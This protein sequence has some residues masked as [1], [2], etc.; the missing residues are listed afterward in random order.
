M[1]KPV[2]WAFLVSGAVLVVADTTFWAF[3]ERARYLQPVGAEPF[4]D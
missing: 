2:P 4:S 3:A 1:G